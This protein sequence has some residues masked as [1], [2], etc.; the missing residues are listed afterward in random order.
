ML[1][2]KVAPHWSHVNRKGRWSEQKK[3]PAVQGRGEKRNHYFNT[4]ILAD[5]RVNNK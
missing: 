4:L 3:T 2:V 5:L 1:Q